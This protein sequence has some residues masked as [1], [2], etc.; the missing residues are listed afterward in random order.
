MLVFFYSSKFWGGW[1]TAN[2]WNGASNR[3][4]LHWVLQDELTRWTQWRDTYQVEGATS[5]KAH[6]P[7]ESGVFRELPSLVLSRSAGW[8][9]DEAQATR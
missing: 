7:P 5:A 3:R 2:N 9:E 4:Q 1:Y 6:G 8:Q